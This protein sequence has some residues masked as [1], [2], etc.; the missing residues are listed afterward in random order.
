MRHHH[1]LSQPPA[2]PVEAPPAEPTGPQ[3]FAHVVVGGHVTPRTGDPARIVRK[4]SADTKTDIFMHAAATGEHCEVPPAARHPEDYSFARDA[5]RRAKS[6]DLVAQAVP[7]LAADMLK[8]R[9]E[10]EARRGGVESSSAPPAAATMV[11]DEAR[12]GWL[13]KTWQRL[14][15]RR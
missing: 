14:G 15:G 4:S 11:P 8:R 12:V 6:D 3:T 7:Q 1:H 2:A 10:Y 5:M 13:R 9:G